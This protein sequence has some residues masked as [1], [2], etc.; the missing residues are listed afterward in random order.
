MSNLHSSSSSS[1]SSDETRALSSSL[2]TSQARGQPQQCAVACAQVSHHHAPEGVVRPDL[3]VD[4]GHAARRA[5]AEEVQHASGRGGRQVDE[6][7]LEQH[8][9][10]PRLVP[11][12]LGQRRLEGRLVTHVGG[13]QLVARRAHAVGP[14]ARG[15]F[16]QRGEQRWLRRDDLDLTS[17][18]GLLVELDVQRWRHARRGELPEAR[19]EA[20]ADR[21][22]LRLLAARSMQ[23]LL[24]Q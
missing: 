16:G 20:R 15:A 11:S 2:S 4:S 17:Y 24:A 19:V 18:D 23:E 1:G 22:D 10:R 8:Q 21:D 13:K 12:R 9:R 6:H 5:A 14:E 3:L 7:A